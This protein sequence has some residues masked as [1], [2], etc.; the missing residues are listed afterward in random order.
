MLKNVYKIQEVHPFRFIDNSSFNNIYQ[1]GFD[2]VKRI[3]SKNV[4]TN[5]GVNLEI[6]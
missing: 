1:M 6:S 2:Q 3:Y 4:K 5:K